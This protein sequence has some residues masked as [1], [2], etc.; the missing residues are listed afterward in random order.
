MITGA[1][2]ADAAVLI[3]DSNEGIMEQTMRH[4]YLLSMVG[5]KDIICVLV[6]KMTL[7]ITRRTSMTRS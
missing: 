3:I 5:I 2:Y 6:N 7:L 1:S 4:G